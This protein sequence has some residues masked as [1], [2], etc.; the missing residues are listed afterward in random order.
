MSPSCC[1]TGEHHSPKNAN[2]LL[3]WSVKCAESAPWLLVGLLSTVV[4]QQIK[5]P[6]SSLRHLLTFDDNNH[7]PSLQNLFTL[8]LGASLLGLATPLCSCGAIPL[9]IGFAAAGVSP[10]AVVSFL[11]AAQSAGLDSAAITYGMLGWETATFR[12][13]GAVVLSVGAGMAVGRVSPLDGSK[14]GAGMAVGCVSPLDGSKKGKQTKDSTTNAGDQS[15]VAGTRK[16]TSTTTIT[17]TSTVASQVTSQVKSMIKSAYGLLDEIWFVLAIGILVS[18][19]VQNQWGSADLVGHQAPAAADA[20]VAVEEYIP[21]PDWWDV[22]EDGEYPAPPPS[23]PLQHHQQ[24]SSS[25]INLF[26]QDLTTR[27][28]VIVGALPFQLCEHGVVSFASALHKSGATHGTAHAFLLTAPATNIA[29]LG[30][31]LKTTGDTGAA[32]RSAV[33]I[34]ALALLISYVIDYAWEDGSGSKLGEAVETLSLPEWW[35]IMSVWVCGAMVGWSC[36]QWCV[37][38]WS[39]G[40]LY[41]KVEGEQV[42][43]VAQAEQTRELVSK[44]STCKKKRRTKT[45]RGT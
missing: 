32:V 12:L 4:L 44:K 20:A 17:V 40:V 15:M 7:P 30:A 22:E 35:A 41:V 19:I 16:K 24:N 23:L 28:T 13:V 39:R 5:L 29:T 43:H 36:I 45:P 26:L 21:Q 6:T 18:V 42:I 11:T 9:A 34:S 10:A 31:V 8:T 14:K 38:L 3:Q 1:N 2:I 25:V 37:D 27:V 33:T